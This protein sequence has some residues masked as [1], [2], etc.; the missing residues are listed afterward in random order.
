MIFDWFGEFRIIINLW[1]K[2]FGKEKGK[3]IKIVNKMIFGK[4]SECFINIKINIIKFD[5]C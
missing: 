5:K 1:L 2:D 3:K 4:K